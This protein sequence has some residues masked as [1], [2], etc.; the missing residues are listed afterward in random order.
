MN[1][2]TKVRSHQIAGWLKVQ[3]TG[4][5]PVNGNNEQVPIEF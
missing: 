2:D 3:V 4:A 1:P 5:E